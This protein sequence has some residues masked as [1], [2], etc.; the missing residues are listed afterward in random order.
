M[1]VLWGK[2]HLRLKRLACIFFF[3]CSILMAW[4][5]NQFLELEGRCPWKQPY[6]GGSSLLHAGY[7]CPASEQAWCFTL[8]TEK[9]G[10]ER[11]FPSTYRTP[12]LAFPLASS[13]LP[14]PKYFQLIFVFSTYIRW[15]TS[16]STLEIWTPASLGCTSEE[17]LHGG[18]ERNCIWFMWFW[19]C[20]CILFCF[21]GRRWETWTISYLCLPSLPSFFPLPPPSSV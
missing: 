18:V 7:G 15:L 16:K 13:K 1:P 2:M 9:P 17:V 21:I 5:L 20:I 12:L 11:W 10:T 4:T 3:L 8:A 19:G 6:I 14:R